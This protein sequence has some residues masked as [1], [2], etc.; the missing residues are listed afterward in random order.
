M[1]W[2]APSGNDGSL[3]TGYRV[4]WK[5]GTENYDA[6]ATSTRQAV[7]VGGDRLTYTIAGLTN[8]TDYTVR[9][10]GYNG[11]EDGPASTEVTAAPEAPNIVVI[12]VDDLGY[13]DAGFSGSTVGYTSLVETP[14]LDGLAEEGVVF[15]DGYVTFSVCTP[16]RAGLLTGRY[17]SRFGV[18]GNIAYNPFDEHLGLPVEETTFPSYLQ[19]AGYRTGAVGKWQLGG[20]H[21][22]AP[23]QRGFD[24]F[25]GFLNGRHDYWQVDASRSGDDSLIPLAGN[26][27][28]ASFTGYLADALTDKAIEFIEEDSGEPF[29]LYLAYN[30]PHTPYQ[31]PAELKAKYAKFSR[32][33]RTYLAMVDSL[34]QNVGR[35]LEALEQT[36]KR[37]NTIVF[38]LS[39]NGGEEPAD[40]GPFREGKSSFHEGGIRVPFVASWPA[41]WACTYRIANFSVGGSD[42]TIPAW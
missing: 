5:S 19:D 40:N 13:V 22:F 42:I 20:A 28:P 24:Y 38:F 16:S 7:L 32:D 17:P 25:Y 29:F 37:D 14:N 1:S 11:V 35:L 39:D 2:D 30:A 41:R 9:V 8:G 18:E 31:A 36:G 26:T 23:L 3:I 15:T 33:K 10:I 4:Q 34:D 21:I 27:S 6:T 12:L